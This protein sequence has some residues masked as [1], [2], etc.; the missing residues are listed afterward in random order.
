MKKLPIRALTIVA[1][2]L[3]TAILALALFGRSTTIR[4]NVAS[5]DSIA[6]WAAG[7]LLL[8]R[9]DPYDQREVLRLERQHGYS[10]DRPLVLRTPPWS[11]FLVV[12]LG[13]ADPFWSW[14]VWTGILIGSLVVG[15]RLCRRMYG[16][17]SVPQNLFATVGYLF[18]PVPAC[19]VAGQMGLVLMLGVALFLLW[20]KEHPFRAGA[21]LILP[22]AKPHLLSLFW[23]ILVLWVILYK[24]LRVATGFLLTFVVVTLVPLALDRS[25]FHDYREML[26][27]AS[28][29]R[30]FIPALSGVIRLLFFR[31]YFWVQFL[32]LIVGLIWGII[33]FIR[34]R[35]GWDWRRDGPA[36]LVVSVLTTPYGWLADESVLLP[37]ILQ[38]LVLIYQ[39]RANMKVR[40]KVALAM[41]ALLNFL[42]LLILRSKIPFSTGIYFWSTLVWFSW[43]FYA[44]RLHTRSSA[45]TATGVC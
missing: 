43:Y 44:S 14:L 15:M 38:A 22:F 25:I 41:F 6:Y 28:I 37:A 34:R 24:Q 23:L 20:E 2:V 4:A 17:E 5:R 35:P 19:L 10:A 26:H 18:A 27:V 30:E 11:L 8:N 45:R 9:Q 33:F 42:L 16:G 7:H 40:T 36:L 29:Q 3:G 31:N 1:A 21:V 13:L 12:P 39:V 32:P